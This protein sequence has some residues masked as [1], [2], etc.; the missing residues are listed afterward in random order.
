MLELDSGMIFWTWVT[1]FLL[2]LVLRKVAWKPLL[3]AVEARE[4]K[5]S[6]SLRRA[7]EAREEAERL[8]AEHQQALA[9]AQE[10]VQRMLKESKEMAEKMRQDILQ[11]AKADASKM[12]ERAK[13]D[14]EREREMAMSALKQ[15]VAD[16]VVNATAKLIGE[17]VDKSRHAKLIDEAI[18]QLGQKH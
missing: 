15:E 7:E 10:E 8:L 11:Q 1:F 2:L 17:V 4:Q 3:G 12:I 18:A 5:I 16:M 6:E 13:A 9:N 14:I